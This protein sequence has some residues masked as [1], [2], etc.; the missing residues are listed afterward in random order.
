MHFTA[1]GRHGVEEEG[2]VDMSPN[3]STNWIQ[4]SFHMLLVTVDCFLH[5]STFRLISQEWS[6]W[7]ET[8]G[9]FCAGYI[10]NTSNESDAS[11]LWKLIVLQPTGSVGREQRRSEESEPSWPWPSGPHSP[12]AQVVLFSV[13]IFRADQEDPSPDGTSGQTG[14]SHISAGSSGPQ[15]VGFCLFGAGSWMTRSLLGLWFWS[16]PSFRF[17]SHPQVDALFRSHTVVFPIRPH[18][19]FTWFSL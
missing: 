18:F 7:V 11:S 15:K 17:I 5:V 19:V 16:G 8:A 13:M 3:Q 1:L 4:S 14:L 2:G 9:C 6:C 10:F 12:A